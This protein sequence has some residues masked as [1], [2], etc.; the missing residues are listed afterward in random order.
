MLMADEQ[1]S[2]DQNKSKNPIAINRMQFIH[3]TN[4]YEFSLSRLPS[5]ISRAKFSD[6]SS[7]EVPSSSLPTVLSHL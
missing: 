3:L 4:Q 1:F 6:Q 2:E 7:S 5:E